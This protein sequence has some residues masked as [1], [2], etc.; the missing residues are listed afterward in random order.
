M[1][2]TQPVGPVLHSY[3]V[4]HLIAVK[5]LRPASVRSYRDTIRLL[6]IFIAVGKQSKITR[7]TLGDLT[8]DRVVGFLRHLEHDRGSHICTR[9][10]RLAAVHSLFDYLASREPEMLGVCQR[11]GHPDE[12]GGP[13]PDPVPGARGGARL[14]QGPAPSRSARPARPRPGA[15]SLQHRRSGSGH[16][17]A[18]TTRPAPKTGGTPC[19]A[20]S[21]PAASRPSGRRS[22][23]HPRAP[24][25]AR[26]G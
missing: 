24:C 8:F 22:T 15:V 2:E 4:D 18:A 16:R 7:L 3:F 10:Q 26:S 19:R 1:I 11:V 17:A 13:G 25:D 20:R 23:V 14:V 12:K 9:N 21:R 6:L 5:G